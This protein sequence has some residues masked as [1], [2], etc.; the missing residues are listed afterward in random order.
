MAAKYILIVFN[1]DEDDGEIKHVA[2]DI[3]TMFDMAGGVGGTV[4]CEPLTS[5]EV[6]RELHLRADD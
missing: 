2:E 3:A 6:Q 1:E 4:I 5:A